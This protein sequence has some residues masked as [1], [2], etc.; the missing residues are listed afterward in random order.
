MA[1]L[2]W[3]LQFYTEGNPIM[4]NGSIT[5]KGVKGLAFFQFYTLIRGKNG[6]NYKN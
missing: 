1:P 3:H 2:V 5:Y 6:T 4:A